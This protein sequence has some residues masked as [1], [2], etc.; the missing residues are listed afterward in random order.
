MR[1]PPDI[2]EWL[3][4]KAALNV[5]SMTTEMVRVVRERMAHERRRECVASGRS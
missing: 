5:S 3:K 2:I 4:L 1:L